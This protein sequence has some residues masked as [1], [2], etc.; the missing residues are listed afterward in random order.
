MFAV[1]GSKHF[2]FVL[3]AAAAAHLRKM[4]AFA[5][6]RA[7]V[8]S[9][10]NLLGQVDGQQRITKFKNLYKHTKWE[11]IIIPCDIIWKLKR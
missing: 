3:L 7:R 10:R 2:C 1:V 8:A 5:L 6:L 4:S 9:A 11:E